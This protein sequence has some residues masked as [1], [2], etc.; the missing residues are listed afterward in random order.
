MCRPASHAPPF[1]TWA[2]TSL[3]SLL[4]ISTSSSESGLAAILIC[5]GSP[6]IGVVMTAGS[7]QTAPFQM[8]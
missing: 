3:L 7:D 1:Q 5:S 4:T 8:R 6:E 2:K